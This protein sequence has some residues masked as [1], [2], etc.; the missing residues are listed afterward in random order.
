MTTPST[1][2]APGGS[3]PRLVRNPVRFTLSDAQKAGD[4]WGFNCGPGALCAVLDMTP[5][6]LRPKLGDFERK[7]YTNPTLMKETLT[8]CGAAQFLVHRSDKPGI[9]IPPKLD[10]ALVR[11]QWAGP[12]TQPGVPW[13]ARYRHTHWIGVRNNSSEIFDINAMCSG[14]WLPHD[15]WAYQL[16]PWLIGKVVPKGDG[17][18]WPTHAIA[19]I[20]NPH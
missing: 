20:P 10:L 9:G 14:G 5:D 7:G 17:G 11:V 12:W 3:L 19:V 13:A 1:K 15:E 2:T 4:D 18:W 8:R 6:E 16:V